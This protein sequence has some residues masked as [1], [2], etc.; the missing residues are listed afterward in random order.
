MQRHDT[1][2]RLIAFVNHGDH[3]PETLIA[4]ADAFEAA[5]EQLPRNLL[6]EIEDDIGRPPTRLT[7][8]I[9]DAANPQ[10]RSSA[11]ALLAA[12]TDGCACSGAP[13]PIATPAQQE[14]AAEILA[15]RAIAPINYLLPRMR[16]A[17]PTQ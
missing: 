17:P 14:E 6:A 9:R 8:A 13:A 7:E 10:T 15:G 5:L 4:L 2:L 3:A 16:I 1:L 12:N 11:A